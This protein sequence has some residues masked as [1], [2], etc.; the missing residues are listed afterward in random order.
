MPE[1]PL[2][3]EEIEQHSRHRKTDNKQREPDRMEPAVHD[4]HVV[5]REGQAGEKIGKATSGVPL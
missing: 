2:P 4:G 1:A 3:V 5:Q